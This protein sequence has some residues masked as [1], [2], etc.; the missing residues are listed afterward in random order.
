MIPRW[1]R[2]ALYVE[3]E[4]APH[5]WTFHVRAP[6]EAKARSLVA[7]HL[8]GEAHTIYV[9]HPSDPLR[10]ASPEPEIA[11]HYGPYR[12]SWKDPMLAALA[13]SGE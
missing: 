13:T 5:T 10:S 7:D 4:G 8:R 2:I 6:T 11:A 12:R 1:W 9:C 3:R